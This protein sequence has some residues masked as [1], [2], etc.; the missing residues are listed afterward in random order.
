MDFFQ[1][2]RIMFDSREMEKLRKATVYVAG[3]GGLGSHQ[4]L[5][6]QR[7]GVRK[8][9]ITDIDRVEKT[10]LN[11]Q[12]LYGVEDIGKQKVEQAVSFLQ[13][14]GL[15][16]EIVPRNDRVDLDLKIP[17]DVDVVLD[18]LDSFPARFALEE[19][20]RKKGVP[21]IHGAVH[22]W[23]GQLTTILPGQGVS[24][25]DIFPQET[26]EEEI[27][28]FS[29]VVAIV[30]SLQVLEAVKFITGQDELLQNK[31]LMIDLKEYSMDIV[32]I[33]DDS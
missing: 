25:K 32:E 10:N 2:H 7:I 24:L 1:R 5:E 16:T 12:I 29:P 8:I 31:L 18:A 19:A 30:A 21:M 17:E 27:P 11:R 26:P 14:F 33:K 13:R 28:A 15:A 23:Y 20:A 6:L 9:Y 4:A 3:A 22:S